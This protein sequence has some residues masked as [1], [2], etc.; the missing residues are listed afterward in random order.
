MTHP[1][2]H[3][4]SLRPFYREVEW[5]WSPPVAG[6]ERVDHRGSVRVLVAGDGDLVQAMTGRGLKRRG[7]AKKTKT[8][9]QQNND[10]KGQGRKMW[11]RLQGAT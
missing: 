1:R 7:P 10:H 8:T 3:D 2:I 6:R 11:R 9:K 4:S 5:R